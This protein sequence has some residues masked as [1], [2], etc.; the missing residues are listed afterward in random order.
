MIL[1]EEELK[2][3][4]YHT[5]WLVDAARNLTSAANAALESGLEISIKVETERELGIRTGKLL[6]IPE[7]RKKIYPVV[8]E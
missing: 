7:I 2:Q 3:L 4:E 8:L 1:D 5:N 6:V